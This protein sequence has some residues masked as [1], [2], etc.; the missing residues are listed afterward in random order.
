MVAATAHFAIGTHG[1]GRMPGI[2]NTPIVSTRARAPRSMTVA[3]PEPRYEY[4]GIRR[5]L[6]PMLTTTPTSMAIGYSRLR[7]TAT[8]VVNASSV[9]KCRPCPTTS[10]RAAFGRVRVP[11]GVER[12][13]ERRGEDDE[14][15]ARAERADRQDDERVAERPAER[16][17]VIRP[18]GD[19]Q[20]QRRRDHRERDRPEQVRELVADAVD[21]DR[22]ISAS[23]ASITMSIRK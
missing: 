15:H 8:S 9:K 20:R 4:S 12:G 7:P 23:A 3:Q 1:N 6:S 18:G 22:R 21:A 5:R 10:R 14:D 13:D 2:R 16:G 19:H 17:D 11:L